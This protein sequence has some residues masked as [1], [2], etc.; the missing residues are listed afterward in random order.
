[1][2]TLTLTLSKYTIQELWVALEERIQRLAD[3]PIAQADP[4]NALAEFEAALTP[5]PEEA[6][7]A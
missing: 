5:S 2:I 1:M 3:T 7:D 4:K 6:R